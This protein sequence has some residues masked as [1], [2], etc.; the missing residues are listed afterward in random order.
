MHRPWYVEAMTPEA[1]DV[2]IIL[3]ISGSMRSTIPEHGTTYLQL[4]QTAA[5]SVLGSLNP[6]D[7]VCR[8]TGQ[9]DF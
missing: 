5:I 4:A 3:D 7:R 2:V 9:V 6:I 8:D 1:K